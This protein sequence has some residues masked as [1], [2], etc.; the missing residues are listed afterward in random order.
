MD[1]AYMAEK[2]NMESARP[3]LDLAHS[4]MGAR[5]LSYGADSKISRRGICVQMPP[6]RGNGT[7]VRIPRTYA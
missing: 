4:L 6:L 1:G 7:S 3:T 2:N 5:Q